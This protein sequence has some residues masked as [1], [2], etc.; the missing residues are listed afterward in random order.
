MQIIYYTT[1]LKLYVL[2]QNFEIKLFNYKNH[3]KIVNNLIFFIIL[4]N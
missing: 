3:M 2:Y 1:N 4:Y